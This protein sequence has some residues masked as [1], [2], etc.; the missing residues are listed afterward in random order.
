[1]RVPFLPSHLRVEFFLVPQL[2]INKLQLKAKME[3]ESKRFMTVG[4][5]FERLYRIR[6]V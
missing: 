5:F 1:M 6:I 2:A 3:M 4:L